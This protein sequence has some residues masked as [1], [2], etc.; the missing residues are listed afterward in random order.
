M[1][2]YYLKLH[3][4]PLQNKIISNYLNYFQKSQNYFLKIIQ[5]QTKIKTLLQNHLKSKNYFKQNPS[6]PNK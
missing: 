2:S 4:E 3:L 6:W 1:S 5:N